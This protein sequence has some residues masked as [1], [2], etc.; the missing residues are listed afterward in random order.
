MIDH[1]NTPVMTRFLFQN[2]AGSL[3]EGL[4]EEYTPSKNYVKINGGWFSIK[5][6]NEKFQLKEIFH[7]KE[8][9]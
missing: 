8:C 1:N 6:A 7:R 3:H 9:R 2:V 5:Q 4:I